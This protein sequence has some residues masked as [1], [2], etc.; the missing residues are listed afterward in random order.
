LAKI[1]ITLPISL[2]EQQ[3]IASI[4]STW[5]KAIEL[6]EK[7][8]SEK[9]KQKIALMQELLTG[10]KRL[11][12]FDGEWEEIR[13]GDVSHIITGTTPSTK[14]EE[15][16]GGEYPWITPTDINDKRDIYESSRTLTESGIKKGRFVPKGSLLVTCIASIGKNAI[17]KVDGSCNQQINAILPSPNHSNVFLYYLLNYKVDT[18]KS[19]AGTSATAIL[20]KEKFSNLVFLLPNLTEQTAI[21]NILSLADKEISLLEKELEALKEQKK[22]LMQLLLTGIVRVN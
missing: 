9:K 12:G 21:A 16:F 2:P 18:L 3:N 1:I 14:V 22:G 5:D 7:L 20:N 6:K 13:L 8:I 4:L 17:L 11:D 19:Y 10:K 15:Y